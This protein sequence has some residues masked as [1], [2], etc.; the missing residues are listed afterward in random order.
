VQAL[1]RPFVVEITCKE[2]PAKRSDLTGGSSGLRRLKAIVPEF[3]ETLDHLWLHRLGRFPERATRIDDGC[4][5]CPFLRKK[6]KITQQRALGDRNLAAPI[7]L[8]QVLAEQSTGAFQHMT[9]PQQALS[10]RNRD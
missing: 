10:I 3:H 4:P 5:S 9:P 8:E 7:L 2:P 1:E 6:E